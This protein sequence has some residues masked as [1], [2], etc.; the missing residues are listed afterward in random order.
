LFKK[1][2][3]TQQF[4]PLGGGLFELKTKHGTRITFFYDEFARHVIICT[5][6]FDKKAKKIQSNQIKIAR[7]LKTMF[8]TKRSSGEKIRII[9]TDDSAEPKR[10]P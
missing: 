5:Q 4:R 10:L 6:G 3:N 1:V 8:T 2:F 7:S 9:I